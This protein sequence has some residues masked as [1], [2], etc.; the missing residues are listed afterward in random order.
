[1]CWVT[2]VIEASL[3]HGAHI[4]F[5][6]SR[7]NLKKT[8]NNNNC[9]MWSWYNFSFLHGAYPSIYCWLWKCITQKLVVIFILIAFKDNKIYHVDVKKS[10]WKKEEVE[11]VS[12]VTQV[13]TVWAVM[14]IRQ[15]SIH[16]FLLLLLSTFLL[17][18][19]CM[20]NYEGIYIDDADKLMD[21]LMMD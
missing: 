1:M 17:G 19:I 2:F 15:F 10:D 13:I 4:F 9:L 11:N 14:F 6:N 18:Q 20:M 21:G 3:F 5:I 7:S 16:F 8:N 12:L